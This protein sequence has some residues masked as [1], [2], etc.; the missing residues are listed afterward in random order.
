MFAVVLTFLF[1]ICSAT[2]SAVQADQQ[3]T[4]CSL[5]Q[6]IM[7]YVETYVSQNQTEQEIIQKLEAFCANIPL[8]GPECDSIVSSYLPSMIQ[9]IINKEPPPVF[10]AT[11]RVCGAPRLPE[12]KNDFFNRL[13]I[14]PNGRHLC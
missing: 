4:G 13:F 1:A 9:W 2:E 8:F 6:L 11:V 12:K 5:C 3:S 10:C 7:Q 14:M